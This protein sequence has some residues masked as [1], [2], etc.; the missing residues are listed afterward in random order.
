MEKHTKT[1]SEVAREVA[2]RLHQ[3]HRVGAP[4]CS[5]SHELGNDL[6]TA[7]AA[8]EHLVA[9]RQRAGR[10]DIVGWKVGLTSARMQLMVGLSHPVAGAILRTGK[11]ESGATLESRQYVH[12]GLEAELAVW[13]GA[14]IDETDELPPSEIARRVAGVAAAFEIVDDRHADYTALDAPSLVA[15]NSWNS[16]AVLGTPVPMSELG[17]LLDRHASFMINGK[18]V[19]EAMTTDP[20]DDPLRSVAWLAAHLAK[21]KQPLRTHQV[22]LTGS[23][24]TTKFPVLGDHVCF[25]I[26]GLPAVEVTIR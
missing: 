2:L 8:Q 18:L 6:N 20:G 25:E 9:R 22:I 26:Q 7:Y 19:D 24:V 21:R 12:I 4:F 16:G 5:L 1:T 10:D 23:I 15:D 14:P 3:S 13:L 11:H 17:S